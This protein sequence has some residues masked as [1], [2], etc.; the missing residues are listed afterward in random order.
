[1]VH[2]VLVGNED[3]ARVVALLDDLQQVP[4]LFVAHGGEPE[5]VTHGQCSS[6]LSRRHR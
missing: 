6:L 3:Q 1:M 5:I 4:E 2:E